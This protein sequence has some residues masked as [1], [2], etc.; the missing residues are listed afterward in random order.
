MPKHPAARRAA[1]Q[2]ASWIE[3][4]A[5]LGYASK[6][7][8]FAIIGLLA[9]CAGLGIGGKIADRKDV[10]SDIRQKPLGREILMVIA[11]GLAGYS[12]WRI[13][14]AIADTEQRGR[15]WKALALRASSFARGG[16]YL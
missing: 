12:V 7:T 9:A 10:F 13:V 14:S 6:G 1:H 15:D 8:V 5:R 11:V 2:T 4:L 3:R 16:V